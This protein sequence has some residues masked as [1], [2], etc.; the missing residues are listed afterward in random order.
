MTVETAAS[1]SESAHAHMAA[2]A[3]VERRSSPDLCSQASQESSQ[4]RSTDSTV[5][6]NSHDSAVG[7]SSSIGECSA[8][9][10]FASDSR[11]TSSSSSP[12]IEGISASSPPLSDSS[13]SCSSSPDSPTLQQAF[14]GSLA[15][16]SMP[17]CGAQASPPSEVCHKPRRHWC[18]RTVWPCFSN[19]LSHLLPLAIPKTI[20]CSW[21]AVSAIGHCVLHTQCTVTRSLYPAR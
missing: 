21:F 20:S 2:P 7:S 13:S 14:G 16:A 11:S 12:G 15:S 9:S 17:T 3:A 4:S 6:A 8:D 10:S 5:N 1:Q 19:P 18:S